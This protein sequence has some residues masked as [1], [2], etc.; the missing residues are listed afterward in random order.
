MK[1][2]SGPFWVCVYRQLPGFW[3]GRNSDEYL[4]WA[5]LA[6]DREI[7]VGCID[8]WFGGCRIIRLAVA[9]LTRKSQLLNLNKKR[10]DIL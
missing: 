6:H 3:L 5:P 7:P 2:V 10:P 9:R 8:I 4:V 1:N